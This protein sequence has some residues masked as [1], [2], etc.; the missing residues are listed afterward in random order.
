M[1]LRRLFNTFG[2]TNLFQCSNDMKIPVFKVNP[3]N[4]YA[5]KTPNEFYQL[6]LD[7]TVKS[8]KRI[9]ISSLYI[10]TSHLEHDL[11]NKI[12]ETKIKNSNLDLDILLDYNRATRETITKVDG[13]LQKESSKSI[14][15]PLVQRGANVNFYL[16]LKLSGWRTWIQK[17]PKWNELS[18][19]HHMKLYIFDDNLIISGANLSDTYFTNR[20]DRYVL[21]RDSSL[22][23]DYFQQLIKEV[24]NFSL[25][26]NDDGNFNLNREWKYDPRKYSHQKLFRTC[27]QN[28]IRA[29]NEKFSNITEANL[30]EK[31][32]VMFPLLQMKSIG[33]NDEEQ[34]TSNLIENCPEQSVMHMATGYFNLTKT[35]QMI[36][37]NRINKIPM[38]ILMASEEANGFFEGNGILQYIPLVYTHYVRIFL[39][40]IRK[41]QNINILY[42]NRPS[43]SFHAKGIWLFGS[44][45]FLTVIGSTNFGYRSVYR[46]NE[47]Q[48]VILSNDE[49]LREMFR[50]EHRYLVT[51]SRAILDK[52]HDLPKVP[53]WV[54][55]FATLFRSYF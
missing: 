33:I 10:G 5:I 1:S 2:Q 44:R 29:L 37:L 46:D 43:W 48:L 17:R 21:I 41:E 54:S 38:S 53:F 11:V 26:L 19:L 39:Q 28:K 34:F 25:T 12:Y 14:L 4:I 47:A 27:A 3:S 40:R 55:C 6:L 36:L 52:D 50:D 16:T 15:L 24:S 42:Y 7:F 9:S 35:Y 8:K 30:N 51:D 45:Y 20:Q 31:D 32:T 49:R 22:V 18:S 13:Q 23:C